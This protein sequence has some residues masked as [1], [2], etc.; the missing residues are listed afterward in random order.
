MLKTLKTNKNDLSS[1]KRVI[2]PL[3][4]EEASTHDSSS[5]QKP[6]KPQSCCN[7]FSG[8]GRKQCCQKQ[9]QEITEMPRYV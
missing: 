8:A 3:V 5:C 6:Y 9:T 7:N 2:I 4:S 1:G